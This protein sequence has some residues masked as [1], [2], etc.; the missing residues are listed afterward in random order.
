M[1]VPLPQTQA[2]SCA[3]DSGYMHSTS[4]PRVPTSTTPRE[5]PTVRKRGRMVRYCPRS[6]PSHGMAH[7]T[8]A[9]SHRAPLSHT[10]SSNRARAAPTTPADAAPT[11]VQYDSTVRQYSKRLPQHSDA[12][13]PIRRNSNAAIEGQPLVEYV[14]LPHL[15]H[16]P[17][18]CEDAGIFASSAELRGAAFCRATRS[19]LPSA[20]LRGATVPALTCPQLPITLE[21]ER[22]HCSLL[23]CCAYS[24]LTLLAVHTVL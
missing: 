18:R 9:V 13:R 21:R 19:Y 12:R 22:E 8:V 17:A 23:T 15:A 11:T 24:T 3:A 7:R 20:E 4:H 16:L 5:A 6:Y 10:V 2:S 14:Y 1:G